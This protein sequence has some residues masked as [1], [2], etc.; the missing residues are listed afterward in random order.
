MT[1]R[2]QE[3]GSD[4][5][6]ISVWTLINPNIIPPDTFDNPTWVDQISGDAPLRT[7]LAKRSIADDPDIG[8]CLTCKGMGYNQEE[9]EG[10]IKDEEFPTIF[11]FQHRPWEE[12][13]P[14]SVFL[15]DS[16]SYKN[17]EACGNWGDTK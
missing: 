16:T 17:I 11:Q 12:I 14:K 3:C 15:I 6:E 7:A 8:E 10:L 9:W 5:V 2:C 13:R 4:N 1:Y